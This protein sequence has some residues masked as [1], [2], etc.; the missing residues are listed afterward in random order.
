[1]WGHLFNFEFMSMYISYL[2]VSTKDQNLGLDAQQTMIDN[3]LKSNDKVISSYTEKE[4]GT[5]K[6]IRPQLLKA[7]EQCE[8]TGATLL[9][10]K[11]DRLSRDLNFITTLQNR[12][13]KFVACDM[14]DAN[15]LTIHIMASIAQNEAKT[16]SDRTKA[17]LAELKKKGVKLG[18]SY[19]FSPDD[20]EKSVAARKLKKET[21]P[22]YKRAKAF[23]KLLRDKD[24][25]Y[26]NIAVELNNNNFKTSRGKDFSA[27]QVMR[28]LK[29]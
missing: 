22:H 14:P 11:L 24:M 1:M 20:V 15:E 7:I 3:Y 13:V 17:A 18:G 10:A 9:I 21:N 19:Q 28:L 6:R 8:S 16:I 4:T 29:D 27:T 26:N 12:G 25:S 23:A 2:R 5:R